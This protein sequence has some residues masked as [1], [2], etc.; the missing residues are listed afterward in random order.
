MVSA[1]I[2]EFE[3]TQANV[4]NAFI[5]LWPGDSVAHSAVLME[6]GLWRIETRHK[7]CA[8]RLLRDIL[9]GGPLVIV[10]R[11]CGDHWRWR[12]RNCTCI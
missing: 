7:M 10:H 9:P 3:R 12:I 4:G 11:D 1:G 5:N 8:L 6:L 2:P